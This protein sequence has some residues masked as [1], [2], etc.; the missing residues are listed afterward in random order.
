[1]AQPVAA[2]LALRSIEQRHR[3]R[4]ATTVGGWTWPAW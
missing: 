1:V 2:G 4:A 3:R